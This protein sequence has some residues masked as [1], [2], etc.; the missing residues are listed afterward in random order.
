EH[1]YKLADGAAE[2]LAATA[3]PGIAFAVARI[4]AARLT[5][6]K[7][8]ARLP[9][10]SF[11]MNGAPSLPLR[12]AG[13]GAPGPHDVLID[14][15]SPLA[16]VEAANLLNVAVP[17]NL[18][19]KEDARGDLEGLYRAALDYTFEKTPGAAITEYAW[20]AASCDGCA[21]GTALG[22]EDILGLGA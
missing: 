4:D 5:F 12:L 6:D 14:V 10:L 13:I 17:T 19:A 18:D 15:L 8:V 3:K 20:L 22:A 16:R 2:A 21:P 7:E 9:P 11:V 1:G